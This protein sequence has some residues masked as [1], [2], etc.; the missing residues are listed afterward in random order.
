MKHGVSLEVGKG[1]WCYGV[2]Y[3]IVINGS[4]D[5]SVSLLLRISH[6]YLKVH[7][8]R[9]LPN[10]STIMGYSR[11]LELGYIMSLVSA[12]NDPL[13]SHFRKMIND[14]GQF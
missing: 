8:Y 9:L 7:G 12:I 2:T 13:G 10:V 6:M 1:G 14:R 11:R 3:I 4:Y 5:T